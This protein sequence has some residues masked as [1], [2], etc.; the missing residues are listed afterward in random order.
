MKRKM[1][2]NFLDD[3]LKE[4]EAEENQQTEAYFDL[5][6]LSI[7]QLNKEIAKNFDEAEKEC[8]IIN[9]W[10]LLR[11]NQI[12]ERI[13]YLERKLELFIKEKNVKT[14]D[15]PNG[16]L[17]FY[18]KPDKVE[19]KDLNLFLKNAKPEMLTVVPETVKPDLNKIKA[20]IKTKPIPPGIE[21]LEGKEE[22]SYKLKEVNDNG[23]EE[24]GTAAEQ[25]NDLR[26][27]I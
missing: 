11:N 3:M 23:K 8:R 24:A 12:Q 6:L 17:K 15:L 22:F 4:I 14:I 21:V 16:T 5:V 18:K 19:I 9:N 25:T 26:V 13:S 7:K 20:Y 27:V 2:N 10:S 1:E